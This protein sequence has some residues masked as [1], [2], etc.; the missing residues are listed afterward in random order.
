MLSKFQESA[1]PAPFSQVKPVIEK[2]LGKIEDAFEGFDTTP[3]S[4]ASLG[5]VYL[6]KYDGKQVLVKVSRPNIERI[7]EDDIY[8]LKKILPLQ[9]GL[10]TRT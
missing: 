1:P 10:S 7:I 8:V 6:A 2:E 5:Q 4:G 3:L 9:H